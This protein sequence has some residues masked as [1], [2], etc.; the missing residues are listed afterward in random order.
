MEEDGAA[1]FDFCGFSDTDEAI[2]LEST[3]TAAVFN[4]DEFEQSGYISLDPEN[5]LEHEK[6]KSYLQI[7]EGLH[8]NL[9]NATNSM[10]LRLYENFLANKPDHLHPPKIEDVLLKPCCG[11]YCGISFS[12]ESIMRARLLI[13]VVAAKER[14]YSV[15]LDFHFMLLKLCINGT[16][17]TPKIGN[18]IVCAEFFRRVYAIPY[19]RYNRLC[20][21][22]L[23]NFTRPVPHGNEDRIRTTVSSLERV[24]T[25]VNI[26]A[27]VAEPLPDGNGYILPSSMTKR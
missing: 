20:N 24:G 22:V 19:G 26:L 2:T 10:I 3:S 12:P 6:E 1:A 13:P 11:N 4:Y 8:E 21:Q 15:V 18:L 23:M 5:D 25:L 17:L 7:L 16:Q 9:K 14:V 27:T